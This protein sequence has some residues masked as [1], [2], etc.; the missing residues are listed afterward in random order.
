MK[1]S[2]Q[3]G[4]ALIFALILVAVL[5]VMAVSMS[6]LSRSETWSGM[7]YRMMTQARYGAEA[8]VNA[9][10]N[11]LMSANYVPPQSPFTGFNVNNYPLT[12]S[13]GNPVYLSSLNSQPSNYPGGQ[14]QAAFVSAT[15][16]SVQAGNTT[17]YYRASA[18]LLSMSSVVP[19]GSSTPT[20]IQT[21]QITG[22]GLISS[23]RNAEAEVVT[24][25][26]RQTTPTFDYAAFA[27]G[28]GC[29]ALSFS[30][31]GTTDS[32]N[33]SL[34]ATNAQ[35]YAT[36]PTTF[37]TYGGNVGTNGNQTDNGSGVTIYG[38]LSSPNAGFGVCSGG[39]VT[40][41]SGG[42]LSQVTGGLVQLPQSINF[43]PPLVP[44]PGTT[45]ITKAQTVGPC[46]V[47]PCS[48]GDISITGGTLTLYPGV[49]NI[50]SLSISGNGQVAI[51]PDPTT[52]LFGPVIINVAGNNQS[53]PITITGNAISNPTYNPAMVQFV[54]AGTG[55]IKIAGNGSSAAVIYA[56]NSIVDF[57][58]N[59][60]FFGSVIA[61]QLADVGNG[62]INYDLS[63]QNKL[64]T[65]GNYTLSSF[66]WNKY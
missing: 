2:N 43:P 1:K 3:N 15:R 65:V 44:P 30:G 54:Y 13:A 51:A 42:S 56:P 8:G 19:F 31:N 21:W 10:A 7:N 45:N 29:A 35:G 16:S 38:T 36:A 63:L 55:T 11:F 18:Q 4:S 25:L 52:G 27:S 59:A 32:Y 22:H 24:V 9:A 12:D 62:S 33:S 14:M 61:N 66:T 64:Y 41:L 20:I 37:N 17:V 46:S 28:N 58:G 40:A 50:N 60:A 26:E 49:Y 48:Y 5:S 47:T 23:V 6:F 34:L 39:S 57:K 53:T